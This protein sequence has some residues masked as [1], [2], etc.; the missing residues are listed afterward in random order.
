M[1]RVID[2]VP[3]LGMVQEFISTR[4]AAA[5]TNAEKQTQLRS[6]F[7]LNPTTPRNERTAS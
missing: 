5:L 6:V 4:Y 2:F 3:L 1:E 7:R